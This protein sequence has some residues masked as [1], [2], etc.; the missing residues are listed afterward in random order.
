MKGGTGREPCPRALP[1]A[2]ASF[3]SQTS[4]NQTFRGHP[5]S[6][7]P[8]HQGSPFSAGTPDFPYPRLLPDPLSPERV[9]SSFFPGH[10]QI[11]CLPRHFIRQMPA[12]LHPLVPPKRPSP[13]EHPYTTR[14]LVLQSSVSPKASHRPP[15]TRSFI[16]HPSSRSSPSEWLPTLSL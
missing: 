10:P 2:P 14:A 7:F 15:P 16:L 13:H 5:K 12:D 4:P 3:F 9:T 6:Y 11:L 1:D 8:R